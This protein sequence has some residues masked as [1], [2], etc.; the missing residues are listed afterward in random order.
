ME[1]L[2]ETSRDGL[3]VA[4]VFGTF[5]VCLGLA[6]CRL[7][8]SAR[9][10]AIP[11]GVLCIFI[12]EWFVAKYYGFRPV[13]DEGA[14]HVQLFLAEFYEDPESALID[15]LARKP[16]DWLVEEI[17]VLAH[18]DVR[19]IHYGHEFWG[20]LWYDLVDGQGDRIMIGLKRADDTWKV[21]HFQSW[22]C[23]KNINPRIYVDNAAAL[24]E[25]VNKTLD[26][27]TITHSAAM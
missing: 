11:I 3:H 21:L 23:E 18:T 20:S 25:R 15:H 8:F 27:R 9:L 17:E 26:N 6:G 10:V 16:P 24:T 14:A 22:E 13:A 2:I 7:R 19:A 4:A 12:S 1:V 5:G